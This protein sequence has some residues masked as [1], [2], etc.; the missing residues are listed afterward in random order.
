MI[1]INQLRQT[2]HRLCTKIK[3]KI[4]LSR[5]QMP[6][7]VYSWR[8]TPRRRK[9]QSVWV[10]MSFRLKKVQGKA[11][12]RF[13]IDCIQPRQPLLWAK[14]S[15]IFAWK[16]KKFM[17]TCWTTSWQIFLGILPIF[18]ICQTRKLTVLPKKSTMK[19][20]IPLMKDNLTN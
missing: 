19:L 1:Q 17:K 8:I 18:R 12:L 7:N 11:T 13:S 14:D 10:S 5:I 9:F 3:G 16:N 15:L 6:R 20:I 4:L 2:H